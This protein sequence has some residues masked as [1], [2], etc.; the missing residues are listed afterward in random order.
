MRAILIG[1]ACV[2]AAPGVGAAGVA[3]QAGAEAKA[4]LARAA[5]GFWC[6]LQQDNLDVAR[7][8][9]RPPQHLP[10]VSAARCEADARDARRLRGELDRI[11][12]QTLNAGDPVTCDMLRWDRISASKARASA[13]CNRS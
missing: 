5:D 4:H 10:K 6:R 8:V 11:D 7:I 3:P 2:L 12:A 1:L 9:G 13:G